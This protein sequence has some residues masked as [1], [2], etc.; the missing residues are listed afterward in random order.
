M[1]SISAEQLESIQA[2]PMNKVG[3]EEHSEKLTFTPGKF[4]SLSPHSAG[5]CFLTSSFHRHQ[6][7]RV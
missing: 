3:D 1:P 6:V 7:T 5:S 2:P 4:A